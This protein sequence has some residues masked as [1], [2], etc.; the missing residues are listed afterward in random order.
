MAKN[1]NIYKFEVIERIIT[2]LD[3][4]TK[5][6]VIEYAKI[7]RDTAVS[8]PEYSAEVKDAFRDA[9]KEIAGELSL[10]ELKEIKKIINDQKK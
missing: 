1:T 4:K 9:Y 3:F 6:E 5:E 2:D 7:M 10:D 8:N